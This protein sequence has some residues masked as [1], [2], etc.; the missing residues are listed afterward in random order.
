MMPPRNKSTRRR[1]RRSCVIF[2]STLP[3][4]PMMILWQS[5]IVCNLER[6]VQVL[7]EGDGEGQEGEEGEEEWKG[8]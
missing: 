6:Q 7:V 1:S 3:L 5:G 8:D 4:Y 2:L